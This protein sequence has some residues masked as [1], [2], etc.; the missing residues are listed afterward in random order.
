MLQ[1]ALI[2]IIRYKTKKKKTKKQQKQK[3]NYRY[4]PCQTGLTVTQT[5]QQSVYFPADW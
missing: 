2:M 1:G 5:K 4:K 3:L